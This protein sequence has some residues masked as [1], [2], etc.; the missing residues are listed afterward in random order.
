VASA[1]PS[2]QVVAA[3]GDNTTSISQATA[4]CPDGT[5]AVGGGAEIAGGVG[6]AV[7][8]NSKPIPSGNGGYDWQAV[9]VNPGLDVDLVLHVNAFAI[10]ATAG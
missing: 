4:H 2:Y 7:L 3:A 8:F 10:C 5:T 1:I 9:G 6:A